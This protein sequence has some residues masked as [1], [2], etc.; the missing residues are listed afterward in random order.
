[1]MTYSDLFEQQLRMLIAEKIE[2]HLDA[3]SRGGGVNDYAEYKSLVGKI[4]ALR[5]VLELADEARSNANKAR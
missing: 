5:E 2:I 3:L 4:A 1:M